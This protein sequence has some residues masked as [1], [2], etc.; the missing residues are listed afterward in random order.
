MKYFKKFMPMFAA[1]G[2]SAGGSSDGAGDGTGSGEGA[3][4]NTAGAGTGD[5]SG[6]DEGQKDGKDKDPDDFDRLLQARL[7]KA[8]AEERKK[9]ASLVKELEKMKRDKMTADELKKYDDEKRANDL[10]ER[11]K[12]IAEKENRYYAITALKKAGLDDGSEIVLDLAELVMGNDTDTTDARIET[13]NK[14]VTK[15]VDSKVNERFKSYGRIPG[16]PN[17]QNDNNED[18]TI[19]KKLGKQ[20]AEQIKKSNDILK[21]YI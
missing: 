19:A 6:K 12:T 7:D 5:G 10:A 21:H 13:L 3:N 1:D 17:N 18:N 4:N 15:M 2:G 9:N 8:M 11:E 20:R 14:L 16:G